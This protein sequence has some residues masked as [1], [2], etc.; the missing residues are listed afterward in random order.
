MCIMHHALISSYSSGLETRNNIVPDWRTGGRVV[1]S[2]MAKWLVAL[3]VQVQV[4]AR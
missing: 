2:S 4:H 3:H 1:E